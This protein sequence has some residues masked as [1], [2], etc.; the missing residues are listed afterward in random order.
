ML[1]CHIIVFDSIEEEEKEKEK[2]VL[3]FML[4]TLDVSHFERS[5]L[6]LQALANAIQK[7]QQDKNKKSLQKKKERK[8]NYFVNT[9]FMIK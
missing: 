8:E 3:E 5:P 2:D 7:K 6:K 1:D 9:R 4:V